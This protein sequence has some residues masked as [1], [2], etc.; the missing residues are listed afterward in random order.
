VATYVKI[1]AAYQ[2]GIL[3]YAYATVFFSAGHLDTRGRTL[4]KENK[5]GLVYWRS[6][7]RFLVKRG[8][9]PWRDYSLKC[10]DLVKGERKLTC[11][12]QL[13]FLF[14]IQD[15]VPD[16]TGHIFLRRISE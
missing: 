9:S 1:L 13:F 14:L 12:G 8:S 4:K 15:W 7:E 3:I 11:Y 10:L 5:D 16:R 6:R 2:Q